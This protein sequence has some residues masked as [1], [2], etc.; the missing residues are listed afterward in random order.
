MVYKEG[1]SCHATQKKI[2]TPIQLL[3]HLFNLFKDARNDITPEFPGIP[4]DSVTFPLPRR[5]PLLLY[6]GTLGE[7]KGGNARVTRATSIRAAVG[8]STNTTTQHTTTNMSRCRPTHQRL[9]PSLSM[10]RPAA[11]L[12]HGAAAPQHHAH[13]A[14]HRACVRCRWFPCLGRCNATHQ[15]TERGAR[16]WP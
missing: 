4:P 7:S 9:W 11:P 2:H 16:S 10:G 5:I 8:H 12:N 15:K 3:W 14:S 13:A 6:E 1:L